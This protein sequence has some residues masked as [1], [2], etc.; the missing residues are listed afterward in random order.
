MTGCENHRRGWRGSPRL[1]QEVQLE[2]WVN[3]IGKARKKGKEI[4]ES[5]LALSPT[6][7]SKSQL[8]LCGKCHEWVTLWRRP[9]VL[10]KECLS[11]VVCSW[12]S[13]FREHAE[14]THASISTFF[15]SSSTLQRKGMHVW[16][17]HL[18]LM[19]LSL[20]Q[21][22][23]EPALPKKWFPNKIINNNVG[24]LFLERR[25]VSVPQWASKGKI[26]C[27]TLRKK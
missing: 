9:L 25:F 24:T 12:N 19:A 26:S 13:G 7:S 22:G 18:H 4:L 21:G 8:Q 15:V 23:G 11:R 27:Y 2:L 1:L 14:D 16:L 10:P 17:K 3:K 5:D 6:R 20:H